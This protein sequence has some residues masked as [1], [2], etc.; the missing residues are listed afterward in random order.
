MKLN[1][2]RRDFLGGAAAASTAVL[3]PSS[4]QALALDSD[5]K[6]VSFRQACVTQACRVGSVGGEARQGRGS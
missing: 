1:L 6:T 5:K 3:L 4:A 2:S